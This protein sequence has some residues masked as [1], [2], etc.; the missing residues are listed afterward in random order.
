VNAKREAALALL[1]IVVTAV[2]A[3][4]VATMSERS[5]ARSP[6]ALPAPSPHP[7]SSPPVFVPGIE[8]APTS[9]IEPDEGLKRKDVMLERCHVGGGIP[10][11]GYGW[12]VVC[13]KPASAD[14][15]DD[16]K[17]EKKP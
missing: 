5:A 14:W 12:R 2:V 16:P 4:G 13:L 9:K 11:M 3:W 17:M 8:S 1:A 10:V 15:W 7:S 6:S